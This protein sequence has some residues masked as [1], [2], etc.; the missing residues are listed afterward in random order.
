MTSRLFG[1]RVCVTPAG[2][3][4]G[5]H[6]AQAFIGEGASVWLTDPDLDWG[7]TVLPLFG[8]RSSLM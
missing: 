4:L 6:L 5:V 7:S 1:K 2:G 3:R 8:H